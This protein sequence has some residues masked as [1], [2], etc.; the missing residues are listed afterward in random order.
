MRDAVVPVSGDDRVLLPDALRFLGVQA[1][2]ADRR[3]VAACG[4]NSTLQQVRGAEHLAALQDVLA[5]RHVVHVDLGGLASVRALGAL[6]HGEPRGPRVPHAL[7]SRVAPVRARLPR[8]RAHARVRL[9]VRARVV[10]R[11]FL[12]HRLRLGHLPAEPV[13]APRHVRDRLLARDA[14]LRDRPTPEVD[15][16]HPRGRGLRERCG[17][18]PGIDTHQHVLRDHLPVGQRA[19]DLRDVVRAGFAALD[20]E[21]NRASVRRHV[22][23]SAV[24]HVGRLA[25]GCVA[26]R[27]HR[28]RDADAVRQDRVEVHDLTEPLDRLLQDLDL[29]GAQSLHGN[30]GSRQLHCLRR[31]SHILESFCP[32][33]DRAIIWEMKKDRAGFLG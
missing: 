19:D 20:D 28:R 6:R 14:R 2:H 16:L 31:N 17:S 5:E 25:C 18:E 32:K 12:L 11:A 3:H 29:H 22:A 27:E 7:V 23:R 15:I 10:A 4:E 33:D 13:V 1:R 9:R 24:E 30:E 26:R 21:S 8:L